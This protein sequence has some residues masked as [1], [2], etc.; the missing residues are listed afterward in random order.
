M[1]IL[2]LIN[3]TGGGGTENYIYSLIE[4]VDRENILVVYNEKGD[5]YQKFENLGINMIQMDMKSFHDIKASKK[6]KYICSEY[7]IDI[8]HTHFLRENFIAL[9]S[10]FLGN[11]VK[12][13][14]TRHML[15][16]NHGLIKYINRFMT[17]FN[18]KII[19]VSQAVERLLFE[20]ISSKN[21]EMIYTGV[22][23]TNS[24]SLRELL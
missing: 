15:D 4:K 8:V 7:K 22:D 17:R 21:I 11:K 2:H 12:V 3:Y 23:L 18:H 10:K 16:K 9:I 20:E 1:N 19:A 24:K 14:N 6:L 13:I 5:G